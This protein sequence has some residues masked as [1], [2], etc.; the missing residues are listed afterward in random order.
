V[1]AAPRSSPP[2]PHDR[3]RARAPEEDAT[4]Y[5]ARAWPSQ[6]ETLLAIEAA[7][8]DQRCATV[9]DDAF[10]RAREIVR[11]EERERGASWRVT[12]AI[13]DALFPDGH[14]YAHS[15]A[16]LASLD[17]ITRAEA[18]AFAGAHYGTNDAV[19]VVS[20]PV[21]RARVD[22]ALAPLARLG[23]EVG[24]AEIAEPS[25]VNPRRFDART[26]CARGKTAWWSPRRA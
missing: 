14:R 10:A 23:R 25:L 1:L 18:C 20:G 16:T 26:A 7:R 12:T 22:A 11:N 13:D 8:L 21:D 3:D 15:V 2:G 24:A 9:T 19:V 17:R 4:T 6:L 5:T